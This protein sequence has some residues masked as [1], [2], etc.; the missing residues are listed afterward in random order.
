VP[1]TIRSTARQGR[2]LPS[3]LAAAFLAAFALVLPLALTVTPAAA[4]PVVETVPADPAADPLAA[5]ACL[6]TFGAATTDCPAETV[7]GT[8]PAL[9]P[10]VTSDWA[11]LAAR[12]ANGIAAGLHSTVPQLKDSLQSTTAPVPLP[13]AGWML[14]AG[15]GALGLFRRR[16]DGTPVPLRT[17]LRDGA[18]A[19]LGPRR[20]PMFL[21]LPA[22]LRP[23]ARRSLLLRARGERL[24][25]FAPGRAAPDHPRGGAGTRPAVSAE[26][27]PPAAPG[28]NPNPGS[29]PS[30]PFRSGPGSPLSRDRIDGLAQRFFFAPAHVSRPH[31]F[32]QNGQR[33]APAPRLPCLHL[34]PGV[35]SDLW[36]ITVGVRTHA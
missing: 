15:L 7:A 29:V 20:D 17:A 9:A 27:A 25:A 34:V 32:N 13:A 24:T 14:V 23:G 35:R 26:R 5:K 2:G 1:V 6:G 8:V 11:G 10:D 22:A 30:Y 21:R 18:R 33:P 31:P 36:Q 28:Q 16:R 4:A 19:D 3:R 12:F